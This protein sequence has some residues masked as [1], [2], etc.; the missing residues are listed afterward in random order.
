M[1]EIKDAVAVITGGASG[2]GLSC[3]RYWALQGGK[4]VIADVNAEAL[5]QARGEGRSIWWRHL[6]ESLWT[7]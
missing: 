7:V 3:A 6:P 2:I 5:N 1:L 4:V